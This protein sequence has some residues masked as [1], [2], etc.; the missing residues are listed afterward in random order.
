MQGIKS[1]GKV[2]L[3]T[4][5]VD[6]GL[7]VQNGD[8]SPNQPLKV[9]RLTTSTYLVLVKIKVPL[10]IINF[11]LVWSRLKCMPDSSGHYM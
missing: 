1:I 3:L 4:Q 7:H 5:W 11:Y 6:S 2:V 10:P 9:A 8:Q